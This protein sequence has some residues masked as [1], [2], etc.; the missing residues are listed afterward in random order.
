MNNTLLIFNATSL[1]MSHQHFF[2]FDNEQ[3]LQTTSDSWPTLQPF[4]Q[5]EELSDKAIGLL[6]VMQFL[7]REEKMIVV[8]RE[9]VYKNS[10]HITKK[11][12]NLN[13]LLCFLQEEGY[14]DLQYAG[15][16]GRKQ[17]ITLNPQIFLTTMFKSD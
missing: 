11:A 10:R 9:S 15:V 14:L 1:C 13:K 12:A 7:A 8:S 3:K 2:Y 6:L 4:F 17:F 5:E 16:S